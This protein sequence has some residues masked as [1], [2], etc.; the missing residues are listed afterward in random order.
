MNLDSFKIGDDV[1]INSK[2]HGL[3][4]VAGVIV[5][6]KRNFYPSFKSSHEFT[7]H[8]HEIDDTSPYCMNQQK[9][10]IHIETGE[11]EFEAYDMKLL[12]IGKENQFNVDS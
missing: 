11:L 8:R 2:L 6:I 4:D 3:K 10:R 5:D 7:I 1:L 9:Y 12:N